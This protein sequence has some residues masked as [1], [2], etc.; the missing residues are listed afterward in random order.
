MKMTKKVMQLKCLLKFYINILNS[1][2]QMWH[3]KKAICNTFK[4]HKF[5]FKK[6]KIATY[7][8]IIIMDNNITSSVSSL[9]SIS[10]F[11]I[12]RLR[13]IQKDR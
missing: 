7:W 1:G 3:Y 5:I 6:H 10:K 8:S 4:L 12:Q 13:V 2:K 9:L 11:L